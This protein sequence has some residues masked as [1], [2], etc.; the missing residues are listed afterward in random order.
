MA[1][2]AY[3]FLTDDAARP[4]HGDVDINGREGSIEITTIYQYREN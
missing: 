4:I 1:I 2:P 3:L